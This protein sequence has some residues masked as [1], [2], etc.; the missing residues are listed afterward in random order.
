VRSELPIVIHADESRQ[1]KAAVEWAVSNQVKA[2]I[3]GGRDAWMFADL[4]ATNHVSVICEGIFVPPARDT[5]CYDVHFQAPEILRAA[6]VKF[7]LS[8]G[9]G[10]FAAT[11]ERNLPYAAAQAIAFGLPE[12]EALKAITLIPAELAGAADRLGSIEVGKDATLFVCD[13]N[14]FDIRSNVKRMWIAGKEVSLETRHTRLYEKF[15]N[16]PK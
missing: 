14:L 5:E 12:S 15:R 11:Q 10:G 16:R 3:A 2:I 6:G 13:R 8:L 9:Q 4:L 1:I 7:A